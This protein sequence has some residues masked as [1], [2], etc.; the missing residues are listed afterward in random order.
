MLT[1]KRHSFTEEKLE[2]HIITI[3]FN[4]KYNLKNTSSC[5]ENSLNFFY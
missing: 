4:N 2:M 3:H 5:S 1:D